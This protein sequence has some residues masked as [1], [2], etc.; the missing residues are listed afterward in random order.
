MLSSLPCFYAFCWSAIPTSCYIFNTFYS[1]SCHFFSSICMLELKFA[2]NYRAASLPSQASYAILAEESQAFFKH[3]PHTNSISN[4]AFLHTNYISLLS[5]LCACVHA[6]KKWR[7]KG[8]HSSSVSGSNRLVWLQTWKKTDGL[9]HCSVKNAAV[10]CEN[11]RERVAQI[12]TSPSEE[13][14]EGEE[15]RKK[16]ILAVWW[17]SGSVFSRSFLAPLG[18]FFV[19]KTLEDER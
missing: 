8:S 15:E 5:D 10:L 11:H 18:V 1:C 13:E 16:N 2:I 6:K 9:V 14:E 17:L 3:S 12:W 19:M 7:R 4:S